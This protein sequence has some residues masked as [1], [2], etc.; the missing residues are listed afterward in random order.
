M[1]PLHR[2]LDQ[3]LNVEGSSNCCLLP[4]NAHQNEYLN[5]CRPTVTPIKD[6]FWNGNRNTKLWT[7]QNLRPWGAIF[8]SM[9]NRYQVFFTTPSEGGYFCDIFLLYIPRWYLMTSSRGINIFLYGIK[10]NNFPRE[11]APKSSECMSWRLTPV[12]CVNLADVVALLTD[13]R[14]MS[15]HVPH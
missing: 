15:T 6:F 11:R 10:H 14:F 1:I 9:G 3:G 7:L 8:L 2:S 4:S 13:V 5:M 12:M